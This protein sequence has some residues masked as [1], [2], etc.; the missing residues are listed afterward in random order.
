MDEL[1]KLSDPFNTIEGV[2]E[3]AAALE[4]RSID[5]ASSGVR[6]CGKLCIDFCGVSGMA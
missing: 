4:M 2:R 5:A 6:S 1:A 3:G